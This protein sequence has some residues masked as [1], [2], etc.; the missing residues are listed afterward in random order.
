MMFAAPEREVPPD[1]LHAHGYWRGDHDRTRRQRLMSVRFMALVLAAIG[2]L[3][4]SVFA[5]AIV[6]LFGFFGVGFFG[7][8]LWFICTQVELESDGG[9]GLFAAQARA[10]Q[11]MS[12]SERAAQRHDQSLGIRTTRFFR[13]VGIG[14]TVLGFAGFLY[15]QLEVFRASGS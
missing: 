1:H 7:L 14:L 3:F 5:L 8:L 12:R 10:K 4:A 2:W 6:S 13:N 11:H 9:A 15:F